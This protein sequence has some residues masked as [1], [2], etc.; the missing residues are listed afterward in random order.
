MTLDVNTLR[1]QWIRSKDLAGMHVM[2]VAKQGEMQSHDHVF[3]EIVYVESGTAEHA[4]AGGTRRLR[5]GDVIILRPRVWH[6]YTRP[7]DLSIINCLFETRTIQ[8]FSTLL[9]RVDGVFELF[10]RPSRRAAQ[11][12]PAVLHLRPAQRPAF[13]E[14]LEYI[15][16]EQSERANGWQAAGAVALLEVLISVARLSRD[17]LPDRAPRLADRTEQAVLDT[18]THLEANF[19]R[20]DSLSQLARRVGLSAAHLSR[21]FSRRMGIGIVEFVHQLRCE[22]ACR[23]LRWSDQTI[24]RIATT[25]GYDEIAYFSRCFRRQIGNSPREYLKRVKRTA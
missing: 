21:S 8:D 18:V 23:L 3:H 25:V 12:S 19:A 24:G 5:P 20:P 10:R 9:S 22:E 7:R 13:V 2:R 1:W 4:T 14:R 11:E 17:Q 15:L 6:A 16:R